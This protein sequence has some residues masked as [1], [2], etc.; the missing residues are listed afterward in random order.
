MTFKSMLDEPFK[1]NI[2]NLQVF[3][4]IIF[5]LNFIL[6]NRDNNGKFTLF[7]IDDY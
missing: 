7:I 3:H 5:D 6:R 1:N 2:S 4:R